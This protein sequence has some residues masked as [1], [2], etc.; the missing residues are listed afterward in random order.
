MVVL[1]ILFNGSELMKVGFLC[2]V[3]LIVYFCSMLCWNINS[4]CCIVLRVLF[5][6]NVLIVCGGVL[7][8]LYVLEF[9]SVCCFMDESS[10]Y[11]LCYLVFL[12]LLFR[13]YY[14]FVN[15]ILVW[16]VCFV[17]ECCDRWLRWNKLLLIL[18]VGCFG[19]SSGVRV[20]VFLCNWFCFFL[21]RFVM[22][23]VLLCFSVDI[24]FVGN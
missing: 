11:C 20:G 9:L 5:V 1:G 15:L 13:F 12:M 24:V 23:M 18:C 19:V 16:I 3:N 2:N 4:L 8:L 17:V 10:W 7:V 21:D 22:I 6:I 14:R